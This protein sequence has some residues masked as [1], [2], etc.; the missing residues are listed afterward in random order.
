MVINKIFI[1]GAGYVGLA[2]GLALA[3]NFSVVFIDNDQEKLNLINKQISPIKERDLDEAISSFASNIST[4]NSI[5]SIEDH[6][7][8]LLSLPTNYDEKLDCFDTSVLETTVKEICGLEKKVIIV[9]KSTV[10][11]GF[12]SKLI[13]KYPN[14]K[15]YFSPEFLREGSSYS[16]TIKPDRIILSPLNSDSESIAEIF[17]SS[18][19]NFNIKNVLFMDT[20][21]AESVKLFSNTYLAMRVAFI[22]EIDTFCEEKSLNSMSVINGI[23]KDSRIGKGYNNPSFGYGGYCFPKD[24]KQTKSAF[25]DVPESII[26]AVIESNENRA[27]FIASKILKTKKKIIGF[28]RLNMKSGSDNIRNSSSVQI[29]EIL[30][31]HDLQIIVYESL[32]TDVS[33]LKNDKITFT[34]DLNLFSQKSEIIIANRLAPEIE[35]FKSKTY[36]RDIFYEN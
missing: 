11:I 13:A 4:S 21:E 9:I 31:D 23:C 15:I 28:Y 5:H 26:S 17:C 32:N 33:S 24:T 25:K 10:P 7:L 12:T 18:T 6:C 16:D 35:E 8:V 20:S 2:N 34:N 29:I 36:T 3:K 14:T 19:T 27:K 30:L 1:V 22:N